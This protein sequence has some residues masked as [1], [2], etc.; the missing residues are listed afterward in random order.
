MNYKEAK[1][2]AVVRAPFTCKGEVVSRIDGSK[3][4]VVV[5]DIDRGPGWD[6]RSRSYKGTTNRD[7]DPES[8]ELI[9]TSWSRGENRFFGTEKT[10]HIK[11]LEPWESMQSTC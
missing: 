6:E 4:M 8:G 9:A 5:R 11:T 10:C 7:F 3:T 2:G 1:E